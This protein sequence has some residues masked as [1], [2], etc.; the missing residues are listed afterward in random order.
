MTTAT[1]DGAPGRSGT[2]ARVR[3]A[4]APGRLGRF[5]LERCP[6]QVYAVYALLW[7]LALEGSLARLDP[8]VAGWRPTGGTVLTALALWLVLCCL[9]A[10]DEW[11]DLAYDRVHHPERPLVRG[12]VTRGEL[13]GAVCL[14]TA[15]LLLLVPVSGAAATA[16]LPAVVGYAAALPWLE[17]RSRRVRESMLLNLVVTYPVQLLLSVHV[18]LV[19]RHAYGAGPGWV[20]VPLVAVCVCAFLHVEFARKTSRADRP[21]Q[22]FYS[23]A[24][25]RGPA[26][27]LTLG[28]AA[29]AVL[30]VLVVLPPWRVPGAAGAL[31]WAPVAA[32]GWVGWAAHRFLTGRA[33][34]WPVPPA[35]AFLV[36]V[37]L[38]LA[39]TAWAAA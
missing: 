28:T 34:D 27:A 24:L 9:R 39:L 26:T 23:T 19:Y 38:G 30:L 5:V 22:Q 37:Y 3:V 15:A 35:L 7:T 17:R 20:A 12:A 10:V 18:W 6:P 33:A 21:G 2:P 1:T 13:R 32:A 8:A 16:V 31:A 14:A 11:K 36:T 29:G 25:G 4:R